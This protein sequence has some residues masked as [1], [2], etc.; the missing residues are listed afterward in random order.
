MMTKTSQPGAEPA[1]VFEMARRAVRQWGPLRIADFQR[2]RRA[3]TGVA[4]WDA[5]RWASAPT[6]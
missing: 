5:K 1:N 3:E 2:P 4:V 6:P